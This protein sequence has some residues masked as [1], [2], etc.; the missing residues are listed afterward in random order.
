MSYLLIARVRQA[1]MEQTKP[2]TTYEL[3]RR[4]PCL[5]DVLVLR[6]QMV[7]AAMIN[8]GEVRVVGTVSRKG[9][10]PSNVYELVT[11]AKRDCS[12]E[13]ADV[14]G[15]N[16]YLMWCMLTSELACAKVRPTLNKKEN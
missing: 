14:R 1:V 9:C 6:V 3:H 11:D 8:R 13:G 10:Q 12:G 5:Q 7:L 2:F 16:E 15:M 4:S